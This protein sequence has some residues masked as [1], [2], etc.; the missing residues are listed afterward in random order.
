MPVFDSRPD[1]GGILQHNELERTFA[2]QGGVLHMTKG[3][4]GRLADVL[5][6]QDAVQE[7]GRLGIDVANPDG[8]VEARIYGSENPEDERNVFIS[9]NPNDPL[10][11][12]RGKRVV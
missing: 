2:V 11:V 10:T 5:E 1:Q 8:V 12:V 4:F 9:T 6:P 3:E 7:L